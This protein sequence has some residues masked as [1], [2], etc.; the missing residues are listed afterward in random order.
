M[1]GPIIII[2]FKTYANSIG[3]AAVKLAKICDAVT[4]TSGLLSVQLISLL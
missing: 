3:E 2:N 4:L 1:N